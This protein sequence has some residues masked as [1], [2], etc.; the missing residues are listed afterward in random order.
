MYGEALYENPGATLDDLREALT[1]LEE[2]TRTARRFL[3]S[4]HPET[5]VIERHLRYAREQLHARESPN[6]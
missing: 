1:T 4:G 2:T 3:G 6:A 5:A